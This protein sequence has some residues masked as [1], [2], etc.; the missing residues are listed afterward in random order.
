MAKRTQENDDFQKGREHVSD[1]LFE[2]EQEHEKYSPVECLGITFANEGLSI[3]LCK[4]C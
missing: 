4:S 3:F 2:M 1:E